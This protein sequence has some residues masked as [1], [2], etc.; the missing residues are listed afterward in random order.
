MTLK[1]AK[2][3]NFKAVI[4]KIECD[5]TQKSTIYIV[6]I[7][8]SVKFH[9]GAWLWRVCMDFKNIHFKT[10]LQYKNSKIRILDVFVGT[11]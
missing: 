9:I 2:Y 10:T 6:Y 5:H 11:E 4:V 3:A 1:I 7:H 8:L